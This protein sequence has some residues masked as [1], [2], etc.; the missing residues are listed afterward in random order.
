MKTASITAL[1]LRHLIDQRGGE[2][3]GEDADALEEVDELRTELAEEDVVEEGA[4][5]AAVVLERLERYPLRD[6]VRRVVRHRRV[7]SPLAGRSPPPPWSY[8]RD[9]GR[10]LRGQDWLVCSDEEK[11][12][13]CGHARRRTGGDIDERKTAGAANGGVQAGNASGTN[14]FTS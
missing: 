7:A 9:R 2:Y 6:V 8:A 3:L 13:G 11:R 14:I 12:E 1:W 4:E 5:E 10:R